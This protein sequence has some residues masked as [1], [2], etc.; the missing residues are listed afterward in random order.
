[1]KN[2]KKVP[3]LDIVINTFN[4]KP[5]ILDCLESIYQQKG[6]NDD[7]RVIVADM[8]SKDGTVD[9]VRKKFPQAIMLAS[10]K[11]LGFSK[12]NN[13]ARKVVKAQNVLFL[14]PDTKIVGKVIQK[15][16]GILEKQ[17]DLG[18]IGCKVMLP[19]GRLDYSCHRGLPTIWNSF[20]YFTKLSKLFPKSKYF[21]I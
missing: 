11:D 7:W 16:L 4:V 21:S 20:C 1:M 2:S 3:S 12:G 17:E 18:A 9:A 19:D 15:T 6:K 14:N 13:F 10:K 8:A 5:L